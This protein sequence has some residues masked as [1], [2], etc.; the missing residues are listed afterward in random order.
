MPVFT[1]S[2]RGCKVRPWRGCRQWLA[3]LG[4]ALLLPACAQAPATVTGAAA[5][6]RPA[7]DISLITLERSCFGCPGTTRLELRRDCTA[8]LSTTGNAK[9]GQ[10]DSVARASLP[11]PAFDELARQLLASGF[12]E[13]APS[14]QEAGLQDGSWATL[15]AVRGAQQHAVFRREEAGPVTLQQLLDA[16]AAQQARLRFVP[17]TR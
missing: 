17:D 6:G 10:P 12:F 4:A 3:A 9:L 15:A 16:V 7:H 14:Y 1:P 8:V 5:P 11:L 13:M 2:F